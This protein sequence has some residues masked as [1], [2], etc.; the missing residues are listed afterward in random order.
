[1]PKKITLL[2]ILLWSWVLPSQVIGQGVGDLGRAQP[3]ES[4]EYGDPIVKIIAVYNPGGSPDGEWFRIKVVGYPDD[5][6]RLVDLSGWIIDDNNAA[7]VDVGNEPGHIRLGSCF[8]DIPAGTEITFSNGG[9]VNV[10]GWNCDAIEGAEGIPNHANPSYNGASYSSGG[11]WDE[12]IPMRNWGD[13]IQIRNAE[14]RVID[15]VGWGGDVGGQLLS[16]PVPEELLM[17]D[18]NVCDNCNYIGDPIELCEGDEVIWEPLELVEELRANGRFIDSPTEA[19]PEASPTQ[20]YICSNQNA[21]LTRKIIRNGCGE[22]EE[23]DNYNIETLTVNIVGPLTICSGESAELCA[24]VYGDVASYQWSNGETTPCINVTEGRT[25][26]VTVTGSYGSQAE[27]VFEL[28]VLQAEYDVYS[29]YNFCDDQQVELTAHSNLPDVIYHWSTGETSQQIQVNEIGTY[30]VTITEPNYGCSEVVS[31]TPVFSAEDHS[32]LQLGPE[33]VIYNPDDPVFL[34]LASIPLWIK[35]IIWTLPDG[36]TIIGRDQTIEVTGPGLY[37]VEV[38]TR[39]GCVKTLSVVVREDEQNADLLDAIITGPEFIC[40][41]T[42]VDLCTQTLTGTVT[43]YIWSTGATASCIAVDA[44]GT[45]SVTVSDEQGQSKVLSH[46]ILSAELN[47]QIKANTDDFCTNGQVQLYVEALGQGHIYQWSSGET[48]PQIYVSEVGLYEVTVTEL[49]TGCIDIAYYNNRLEPEELTALEIL[50]SNPVFHPLENRYL[51]IKDIPTWANMITWYKP[52]GTS[53]QQE[54]LLLDQGGLHTLEVVSHQGCTT[55]V[56]IEVGTTTYERVQDCDGIGLQEIGIPE[57]HWPEGTSCFG[58]EPEEGLDDP[59][60]SFTGVES[61]GTYT[62]FFAD[63]M[64]DIISEHIYEVDLDPFEVGVSVGPSFFCEAG[65]V[66]LTAE[67]DA[68]YPEFLWSNGSSSETI[69]VDPNGIYTVTVTDTETGCVKTAELE[70]TSPQEDPSDIIILP[71][72]PVY[73]EGSDAR[74]E[75]EFIPDWV[76]NL[77][78]EK[79]DGSIVTAASA[80]IDAAGAYTLYVYGE[81]GCTYDFPVEIKDELDVTI[82]IQSTNQ[83]LC[84]TNTPNELTLFA[85]VTAA[86]NGTFTYDWSVPNDN[87]ATLIVS[88]LQ[89]YTV[90]ATDENGCTGEATLVPEVCPEQEV[91]CFELGE[92]AL[93]GYDFGEMQSSATTKSYNGGTIIDFTGSIASGNEATTLEMLEI[94]FQENA[95]YDFTMGFIIS[96]ESETIPKDAA[97]ARFNSTPNTVY[98]ILYWLHYDHSTGTANLCMKLADNIFGEAL[99]LLRVDGYTQEQQDELKAAFV[100][101]VRELYSC[102]GYA[103]YHTS[104]IER[105]GLAPEQGEIQGRTSIPDNC[106]QNIL[107]CYAEGFV[108][109]SIYG[110]RIQNLGEIKHSLFNWKPGLVNTVKSLWKRKVPEAVWKYDSNTLLYMEPFVAGLIDALLQDNLLAGIVDIAKMICTPKFWK[111][112]LKA[113]TFGG[114]AELMADFALIAPTLWDIVLQQFDNYVNK[115]CGEEGCDVMLHGHGRL[116]GGV[117][118][119]VFDLVAGGKGVPVFKNILGKG[120]QHGLKYMLKWMDDLLALPATVRKAYLRQS[121]KSFVCKTSAGATGGGI[122]LRAGGCADFLTF[123]KSLYSDYTAQQ[124]KIFM[125]EPT[126]VDVWQKYY[127]NN[128]SA[129]FPEPLIKRFPLGNSKFYDVLEELFFTKQ[130]DGTFK[131]KDADTEKLLEEFIKDMDGE[132]A[133]AQ[134]LRKEDGSSLRAWK[135]LVDEG[136]DSSIRKNIDALSDPDSV[137]DAIQTSQK[138]KPKWPEIQALWKRGN[139]FNAKGRIK[140]GDGFVEVVLKGVDGKAGKRLDT[141]LPP[142]DGKPGQIISRKAT[143]LSNIQPNTFKNYL[144]ELITKY[145]KGAELNSS[146]FPPGTK[147]DGDYK[148]EIPEANKSFFESSDEFK[149]V[150][151]KFNADNNVDIEIIYLAE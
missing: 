13:V 123:L 121:S 109:R 84:V 70:L 62:L 117:A 34:T 118:M 115:L 77:Q 149:K 90:T 65:L 105:Y 130:A 127:T 143:T 138:N 104:I 74:L 141:Y 73:C 69:E 88:E 72:D 9:G 128:G 44:P 17:I 29:S 45:Y 4:V 6:S 144:Y 49:T 63:D 38:Y 48:S 76:T 33:D 40:T 1:M 3:C 55:R 92:C 110:F 133:L 14:K 20:P 107:G 30:T 89:A 16:F 82:L 68:L 102:E 37:T 147:L 32:L 80:P 146:K 86:S 75:L 136:V 15:M 96:A 23:E 12:L 59:E 142:S 7:S 91:F 103:D 79:P 35:G 116:V 64:G 87:T 98:D 99:S 78:W 83:E 36:S 50:P 129:P 134:V 21:H 52:D 54:E 120:L 26:S 145:P 126:M 97:E 113:S 58:W 41:N 25:Y 61:S 19:Y 131:V 81:S 11:T 139:D 122:V 112:I 18:E 150:L 43:Q 27:D 95:T 24:Q 85:E 8:K 31:V 106:G 56:E 124:R 125:N 132:E 66:T 148:L 53:R 28:N 22:G 51:S 111:F 60:S 151:S 119:F 67:H 108:P 2:L 114:R 93:A 135:S 140:Y 57:S 42:V 101:M 137:I 47:A 5:E 94:T 10:S 100:A 39:A 71:E 46:T